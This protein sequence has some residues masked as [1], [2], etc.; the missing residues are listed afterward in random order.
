MSDERAEFA[1]RVRRGRRLLPPLLLGLGLAGDWL[2]PPAVWTI[3]FPVACV[4]ALLILRRWKVALAT[5]VLS[6]WIVIPVAGVGAW[7]GGLR[8][9]DQ[10]LYGVYG[11]G[12]SIP[13]L[14]WVDL[15]RCYPGTRLK[16]VIQVGA[17]HDQ[18]HERIFSRL[19]W[20]FAAMN[21]AVALWADRR[22]AK[23]C[24]NEGWG[25]AVNDY[26]QRIRQHLGDVFN[27][28][29]NRAGYTADQNAYDVSVIVPERERL[30]EFVELGCRI[31]HEHRIPRAKLRFNL[32]GSLTEDLDRV[33]CVGGKAT[34]FSAE[35]L[36]GTMP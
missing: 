30:S 29:G 23:S 9:P 11:S 26:N 19:A 4:A 21:N 15:R 17:V 22:D 35:E 33:V 20:N 3:L 10:R 18:P 27:F 16:G 8:N 12:L 13:G 36:G 24:V 31:F 5:A 28:G 32:L 34:A 7:A 2:S 25:S 1:R 14:D 6:S